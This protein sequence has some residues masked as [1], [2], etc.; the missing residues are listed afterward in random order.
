[1]EQLSYI[2]G[3]GQKS[4]LEDFLQYS[5]YFLQMNYKG[6]YFFYYAVK[7]MEQGVKVSY[8]YSNTKSL[9]VS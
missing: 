2:E 5:Y 7:S 3:W 9:E 1:M 4:F 8:R 6:I